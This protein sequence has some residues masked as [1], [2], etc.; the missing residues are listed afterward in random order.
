M[1]IFNSYVNLP[2]GNHGFSTFS[3][4]LFRNATQDALQNHLFSE[5]SDPGSG[6]QLD[7]H[8]REDGHRLNIRDF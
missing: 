1:A 5:K 7:F 2:E 4:V 6:A 3:V 8:R